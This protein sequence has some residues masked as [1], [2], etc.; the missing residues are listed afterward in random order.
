[1][2]KQS[3]DKLAN[4]CDN[5]L[6][7]KSSESFTRENKDKAG[8]QSPNQRYHPTNVWDEEGEEEGG[9]E[10][11]QCL[12]NAPPALAADAHLHLLALETQPQSFDNGPVCNQQ[13]EGQ[14]APTAIQNKQPECKSHT[15]RR[16]VK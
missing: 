13:V 11:N 10:P 8:S 2:R 1:M 7:E 16:S 3:A 6:S 12:Q 5:K 9:H 15:C 4:H 14:N